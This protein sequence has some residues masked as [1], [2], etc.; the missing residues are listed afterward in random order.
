M[1]SKLVVAAILLLVV[2]SLLVSGCTSS[3]TDTSSHTTKTNS[4]YTSADRGYAITYPDNWREE[5]N[6]S[7]AA[8]V[9]LILNP[10]SNNIN[11]VTVASV[12]LNATT[13]TTL[14]G[15]TDS[16]LRDASSFYYY[17]LLSIENST[18]A[19][20]P[21]TKIVWTATAPQQIGGTTANTQ[22]KTMQYLVVHNGRG[23][24]IGYKTVQDDYN[25]Y[26]TQAQDVINSFK[27]TS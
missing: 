6:K 11:V 12:K 26:L 21:A 10:S 13:G 27:F 23:Y 8:I 3:T 4:T 7:K 1:K 15:F 20:Q 22:I 24:V 9:D 25:T 2:A 14:P 19:G 16:S 5:V 18:L 17:T